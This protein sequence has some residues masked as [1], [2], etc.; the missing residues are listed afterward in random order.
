MSIFVA[1][2]LVRSILYLFILCLLCEW[3]PEMGG[4]RKIDSVSASED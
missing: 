1:N 3:L 2:F 4:V